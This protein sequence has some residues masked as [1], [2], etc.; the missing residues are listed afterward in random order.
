ME[1][2]TPKQKKPVRKL[3]SASTPIPEGPTGGLTSVMEGTCGHS[4][5]T[6]GKCA[7]RY[8]GPTTP[9]RDHHIVHAARHASHIWS[10]AIVSG[11]AVVLTGAIGYAA[12]GAETANP[13]GTLYGEFQQI[14][15]RL[16]KIETMVR[17][18]VDR[19]DAQKPAPAKEQAPAAPQADECTT[20]CNRDYPDDPAKA[21]Q[22]AKEMCTAP[23]GEGQ[24]TSDQ[25]MASC[26]KEFGDNIEKVN[27]CYKTN[28]T[29]QTPPQQTTADQCQQQCVQKYEALDV[30]AE[31]RDAYTKSCVERNCSTAPAP[32]PMTDQ[33]TQQCKD[34]YKDDTKAVNTCLAENKCPGYVPPANTDATKTT[35]LNKCTTARQSCA[36]EAG[37]NAT[38]LRSCYSKETECRNSCNK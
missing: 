8:V 6:G 7:V 36:K 32:K 9:V 33:C 4:A 31:Q 17:T 13:G 16:D 29:K 5:C 12:F 37:T 1:D 19:G 21:A 18:L 30:T 26:Q 10:A 23:T 11:L 3:K 15:Q 27:A 2:K 20:K 25:C 34:K 28:C 35:C 38:S 22:C 24:S 14:N